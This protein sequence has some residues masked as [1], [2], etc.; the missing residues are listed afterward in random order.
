MTSDY[1]RP[2]DEANL[3]TLV[4]SLLF[5]WQGGWC[6]A[7]VQIQCHAPNP[8]TSIV[9]DLNIWSHVAHI[10]AWDKGLINR[11]MEKCV[12]QMCSGTTHSRMLNW[13]LC[14]QILQNLIYLYLFTDCFMKVFLNRQN[15]HCPR[16]NENLIVRKVINYIYNIRSILTANELDGTYYKTKTFLQ[17]TF[18]PWFACK[19]H[20]QIGSAKSTLQANL[21]P[22]SWTLYWNTIRNQVKK[23]T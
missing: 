9:W 3:H 23:N 10:I 6:I 4:T 8:S 7:C 22:Y 17:N 11:C 5:T 19:F 15:E 20:R 21:Q 14:A 12:I 2:V 1:L 13:E 18:H 16:R